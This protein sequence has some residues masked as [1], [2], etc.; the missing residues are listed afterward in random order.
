[1]AE[2]QEFS[3]NSLVV[4]SLFMKN[5]KEKWKWLFVTLYTIYIGFLFK[6]NIANFKFSNIK[7]IFRILGIPDYIIQY[8]GIVFGILALLFVLRCIC[9]IYIIYLHVNNKVP[10]S[11][12]IPS[13]ITKWIA[14]YKYVLDYKDDK[15]RLSKIIN[16]YYKS[17]CVFL[18]FS[19]IYFSIAFYY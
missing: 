1:M 2:Y 6:L 14:H 16:F 17:I 3:Y 7:T 5:N 8:M 15:E 19:F 11:I 9:I 13:F 4:S 18:F 12:F 10:T